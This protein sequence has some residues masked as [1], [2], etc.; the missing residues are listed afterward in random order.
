VTLPLVASLV[1]AASTAD[2]AAPRIASSR[3]IGHYLA[4]RRAESEGDFPKASEELRLARVFD[5]DSAQIR[6]A[7][8]EVLL[9][10]S[11]LDEAEQEARRAVALDPE[12]EAGADAWLML[13][14]IL[15][16][17]RDV[18]GAAAALRTA[19]VLEERLAG[20]RGPDEDRSPSPEP[21]RALGRVLLEA[22]DEDGAAR[23][24]QDLG[25]RLPVEGARG[26]R[27]MAKSYLEARD[28][29]RGERYLRRA[30]D[31]WAGDAEAWK[32]LALLEERKRRWAEARGDWEAALRADPDDLDVLAAL[33]RLSLRL[34]DTPGAQAYFRQL[35]LLDPD[36]AGAVASAGMMLVEARRAGEAISFLDG[37]KGP[38][39]ARIDF[40]RGMALQEERR[41]AEAAQAFGKVGRSEGDLWVSAAASRAHVLGQAGRGAEALRAVDEALAIRPDEVRLATAR[42]WVLGRSGR[43]AEAA[44]WLEKA[45]ERRAR[46]GDEEGT[47]EL[48]EALAE[49]LARAG[50]PDRAVSVL[51]QA[52]GRRPRDEGLLF[53]LGQA[54]E[55]AGEQAAAVAQMRALIAQNPDHAEALNFVGYSYA[56]RGERLDE[57]ERLVSRALELRP[58]SGYF[59]DSL[60]WV[61][62]RKG[63][64]ARA[65]GLLEEADRISG[66]EPTILEHLGDAYLAAG[67]QADAAL[68]WERALRS[69]EAGESLDLPD[70]TATQKAGIARKLEALRSGAAPAARP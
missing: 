29:L 30:V 59:L 49:A 47:A 17:R 15:A 55:R 2:A 31:T 8:A 41:F 46:R 68:A 56:E 64:V 12:G 38:A 42:A 32:R 16:H 63:E 37:W 40:V 45:L 39:D 14:R 23:A 28:L 67:R 21:W 43:A 3:A 44:R 6:A 57:A 25:A 26:Y 22:G 58:E 24:W 69:I 36:D 27:E 20:G 61:A 66:P 51:T 34:G 7:H 9:R 4:A 1:L 5:D 18:A 13:G 62:F 11:R 48:H 19:A 50:K 53:A 54:Q 10:L 70:R 35:R 65:V 33:G 60:G 52:V